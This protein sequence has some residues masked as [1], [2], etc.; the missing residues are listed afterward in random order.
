MVLSISEV[1]QRGEGDVV[2]KG[3]L[4]ILV[5][6]PHQERLPEH[7]GLPRDRLQCTGDLNLMWVQCITRRF[8]LRMMQAGPEEHMISS[9][10]SSIA[11]GHGSLH[12]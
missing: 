4:R 7:A 9:M 10:P 12:V 1:G 11:L 3:G 2:H 6:L 8:P 5:Q